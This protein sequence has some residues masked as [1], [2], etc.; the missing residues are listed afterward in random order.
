MEMFMTSANVTSQNSESV[1]QAMQALIATSN[2]SATRFVVGW[3]QGP[4]RNTYAKE[5]HWC[6]CGCGK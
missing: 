5:V 6:G 1:A 3:G 2:E 4:S